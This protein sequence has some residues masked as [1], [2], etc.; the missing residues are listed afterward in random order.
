MLGLSCGM[1][2]LVPWPGIQYGPPA[3]GALNLNH[4]TTREVPL[5]KKKK[6]KQE[7][8]LA[9]PIGTRSVSALKELPDKHCRMSW[10]WWDCGLA[11]PWG[12]PARL[13]PFCSQR[14]CCLFVYHFSLA[15]MALY[16]RI[17]ELKSR[18]EPQKAMIFFFFNF[19]FLDYTKQIT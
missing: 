18:S 4:W 19:V 5:K 12:W 16:N 10:V 2:D 3:L 9:P 11:G 13:L 17:L 6:K 14:R 15:G 7:K 1:W 8:N